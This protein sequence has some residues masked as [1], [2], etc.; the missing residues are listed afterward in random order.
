[1]KKGFS[2]VELLVSLVIISIVVVFISSFVL[3]LR[4]EKG[5]VDI[6]IRLQINKAAI[7]R[8]LNSDAVFYEGISN[9]TASTVQGGQN[10]RITYNNGEIRDVRIIGSTLRYLNGSNIELMRTLNGRITFSAL[11]VPSGYPKEYGGKHL[12]KYVIKIK[13]TFYNEQGQAINEK[14]E[15][16]AEIVD[17]N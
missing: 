12:Y 9:I 1:M 17:Y 4:D 3:N 14:E 15:V 2:L 16:F 6:D 10:L 11:E 7:S 8:K 13:K 5:N